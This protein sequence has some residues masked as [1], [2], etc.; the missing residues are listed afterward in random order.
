M[1]T[2]FSGRA[3]P[4]YSPSGELAGFISRSYWN[5]HDQYAAGLW[6]TQTDLL[7][8]AEAAGRQRFAPILT[9]KL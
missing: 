6:P 1:A 8:G 3:R 7:E 4:G 5:G 2:E 9:S